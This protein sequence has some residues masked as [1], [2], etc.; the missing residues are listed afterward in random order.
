[1]QPRFTNSKVHGK[2]F[3]YPDIIYMYTYCIG[4]IHQL[5]LFICIPLHWLYGLPPL[6]IIYVVSPCYVSICYT[7]PA[8]Q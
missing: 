2:L 8:A 7:T 4:Y 1:M 6:T 3:P 5:F